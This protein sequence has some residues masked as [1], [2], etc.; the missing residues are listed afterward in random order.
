M[1]GTEWTVNEVNVLKVFYSHFLR[2]MVGNL[3][4]EKRI[5]SYVIISLILST[6]SIDDVWIMLGENSC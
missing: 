2:E 6:I 5:S 1:V 4:N 3:I